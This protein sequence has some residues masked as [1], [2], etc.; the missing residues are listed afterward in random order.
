MTVQIRRMKAADLPAVIAVERASFALPWTARMLE[1]ELQRPLAHSVVAVDEQNGV[2]GFLMGRR[3]PD[4]WHVLDLAV[5]PHW[6]RRGIGGRLL[7]DFL[8]AA[9]VAGADVVLE[10]RRSNFA[11]LALYRSRGFIVT[12]VR[13]GY[14]TDTGEDAL[15]LVRVARTR[16]DE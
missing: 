6:R 3:Y 4:A 9:Q 10:V 15:V 5:E 7:D 11:A 14:Y 12:A 13:R 1:E 2:V 16:E 8:A